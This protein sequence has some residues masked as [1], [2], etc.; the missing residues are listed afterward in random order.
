M[1]VIEFGKR[2]DR[3]VVTKR[4]Q[5]GSS[6]NREVNALRLLELWNIPYT[7]RLLAVFKDY[8]KAAGNVLLF[9][10][11]QKLPNK[12]DSMV[13]LHRF[14]IQLLTASKCLHEHQWA[15][16]D[17]SKSNILLNASTND[18]VLIDFGLA[19]QCDG[20]THPIAG[21]EG[22]IAPEVF[23]QNSSSTTPDIYSSGIVFGEWLVPFLKEYGLSHILGID[24]FGSKLLRP[25]W[26]VKVVERLKDF[27]NNNSE[28][29]ASRENDIP[30]AILLACD[31]LSKMLTDDPDERITAE[32]ALQHPF[33]QLSEKELRDA[34]NPISS[35]AAKL[36]TENV[37]VL[38]RG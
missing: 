4:I 25:S 18:I 21:T 7:V 20:S 23:S 16:L 27:L 33:A 9:P 17:I 24:V 29:S 12:L 3:P 22:Y 26:T 13:T 34:K 11:Y 32:M 5:A 8:Y 2:Y 36:K 30:L 35:S 6:A 31:L 28:T 19:R 10:E 14:I 15:H 1:S 38:Y 37:C